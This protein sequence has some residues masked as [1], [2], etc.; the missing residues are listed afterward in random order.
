MGHVDS[1]SLDTLQD[2]KNINK[3]LKVSQW[4]LDPIT[5]HGPDYSNNKKDF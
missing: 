1:V 2:M 4:F 3:N 5:K